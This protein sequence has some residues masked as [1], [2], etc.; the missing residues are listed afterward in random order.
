MESQGSLKELQNRQQKQC[1]VVAGGWEILKPL[2]S[3]YPS[4]CYILGQKIKK[5]G[6]RERQ[7]FKQQ[8]PQHFAISR[9]VLKKAENLGQPPPHPKKQLFMK[10]ICSDKG[11]FLSKKV[12]EK[13]C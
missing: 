1:T 11:I 7:K 12:L 9:V 3:G 5:S 8:N 13:K 10:V 6:G 4:L 2:K